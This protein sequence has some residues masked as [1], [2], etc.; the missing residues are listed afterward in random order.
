VF[1]TSH[2]IAADASTLLH[3]PRQMWSFGSAA[4]LT[5]FDSGR[6]S[7][8]SFQARAAFDEQVAANYRNRVSTAYQEVEDNLAALRQLQQESVSQAA[9]VTA[10]G[11]ALQQANHRY[12]GGLV[13]YLEVASTE[14][15]ALQAQLSA[16]AI[17]L[18]RLHA[19]VLLV[20]ALGGGWQSEKTGQS[21]MAAQ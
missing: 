5:L 8:Q 9:A 17:Q 13:T 2:T 3:A 20:K 7:A 18:R 15:T 21:D 16:V 14:N 19:S 4:V 11:K 12:K 10:T 6:H 1:C